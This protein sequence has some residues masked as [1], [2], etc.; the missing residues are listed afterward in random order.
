M[1]NVATLTIQSMSNVHLNPEDMGCHVNNCRNITNTM[2]TNGIPTNKIPAIYITMD[3]NGDTGIMTS[4][5]GN[6]DI[7]AAPPPTATATAA[8]RRAIKTIPNTKSIGLHTMAKITKQTF[9]IKPAI[10]TKASPTF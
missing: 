6:K 3:D 7:N 4:C 9:N 10:I 8:K 1:E 5:R 2:L